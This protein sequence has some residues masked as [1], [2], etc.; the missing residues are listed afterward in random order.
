MEFLD[1]FPNET[2][3]R[4]TGETYERDLLENSGRILLRTS[5]GFSTGT[6]ARAPGETFGNINREIL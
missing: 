2:F 3:G 6:C 1:E 5:I 4:Y